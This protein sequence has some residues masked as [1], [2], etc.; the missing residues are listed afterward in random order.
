VTTVSCHSRATPRCAAALFVLASA[1][2]RAAAEDTRTSVSLQDVLD[3]AV[4]HHAAISNGRQLVEAARGQLLTTREAFGTRVQTEGKAYRSDQWATTSS[5][6]PAGTSVVTQDLQWVSS[7]T[8][9]LRLGPAVDLRLQM[10]RSLDTRMNGSALTLSLWVPLVRD[11]WGRN[12]SAQRE[13]A[14]SLDLD[15]S[16]LALRHTLSDVAR[17]GAEAYWAYLAATRRLEALAASESRAARI[18]EETEVLVKADERAAMDLDQARGY[19]AGQRAARFLA[20]QDVSAAWADLVLTMANADGSADDQPPVPPT[21]PFPEAVVPELD[22]ASRRVERALRRRLDLRAAVESE[23]SA[24]WLVSAARND[25]RPRVDLNIEAGYAGR[26]RSFL[27]SLHRNVPGAEVAATLTIALPVAN[28]AAQG[29]LLQSAAVH[30]QQK[31]AHDDLVRR[32]RFRVR[33]SVEALTRGAMALREAQQAVRLLQTTV[34]N[35]KRKFANGVS[36]LFDVLQAEDGLT[37]A[38]LSEIASQRAYAV[39]LAALRFETGTLI[40]D[41]P[42]AAVSAADLLTPATAEGEVQ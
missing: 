21:T 32:V 14:A 12:G 34:A 22:D 30:R 7:I 15:A 25:L 16:E 4:A 3:G 23:R 40:H 33:V 2:G 20:E 24:E 36:T 29:R 5:G 41:D 18:V 28:G 13:R 1:V 37:A 42:R 6:Q 9:P 27:G 10:D 8:K 31:I 26:S 11:A 38:T 39:A 35:E 19:L 17:S